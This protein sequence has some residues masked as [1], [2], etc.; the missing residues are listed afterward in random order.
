MSPPL[1]VP[2]FLEREPGPDPEVRAWVAAAF[3]TISALRGEIVAATARAEAAERRLSAVDGAAP[4]ESGDA[5]PLG[6][7]ARLQAATEAAAAVIAEARVVLREVREGRPGS[8]GVPPQA[9]SMPRQIS[10]PPPPGVPS[11]S[12]IPEPPQAAAATP[13]APGSVSSAVHLAPVE[14]TSVEPLAPSASERTE[15]RLDDP[16]R[17]IA[18]G[19]LPRPDS[20]TPAKPAPPAQHQ[21]PKPFL[22]RLLD[23]RRRHQ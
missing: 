2:S 19:R 22:A 9:L 14:H 10:T 8:P 16:D 15:A 7:Q 11:P 18:V 5:A 23:R 4:G 6:G 3:E 12:S 21:R 13:V 1:P 17:R 20:G